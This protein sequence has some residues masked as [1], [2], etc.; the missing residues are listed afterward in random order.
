MS[1]EVSIRLPEATEAQALLT[2]MDQ[3]QQESDTFSLAD[4][5]EPLSAAQE[6][7]GILN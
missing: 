6:A 7:G 3:L 4:A 2:L 1:E 5:A